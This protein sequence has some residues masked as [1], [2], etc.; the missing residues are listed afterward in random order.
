MRVP[1]TFVEAFTQSPLMGNPIAIVPH[2]EMLD[3]LTMQRIA[4][5]LDQVATTFILPPR[6]DLANWSLRS[7][8][9]SGKEVSGWDL[10]RSA[11]GGGWPSREDLS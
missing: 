8:T 6:S 4:G 9:A 5:E 1:Y 11:P 2:A 3:E 10:I 7:F